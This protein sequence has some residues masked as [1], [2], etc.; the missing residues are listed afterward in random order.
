MNRRL[1]EANELVPANR[2]T[3]VQ[4]TKQA[5][6]SVATTKP[7][8]TAVQPKT[9]TPETENLRNVTPQAETT[10][11]PSVDTSQAE[12]ATFTEVN[13][14]TDTNTTDKAKKTRTT[15]TKS[16]YGIVYDD[17]KTVFSDN[18]ITRAIKDRYLPVTKISINAKGQVVLEPKDKPRPVQP[19]DTNTASTTVTKAKE[20]RVLDDS[21]LKVLESLNIVLPDYMRMTEEVQA[22]NLNS[23]FRKD[24]A[25]YLNS[26]G[27]SIL[28]LIKDNASGRLVGTDNK[29]QSF[30]VDEIDSYLANLKVKSFDDYDTLTNEDL[31]NIKSLLTGTL[32]GFK[33]QL[34]GG[35]KD[36]V[37]TFTLGNVLKSKVTESLI[38]KYKEAN[39]Q[40]TSDES[41]EWDNYIK[42]KN[43]HEN[44][45]FEIEFNTS[46]FIKSGVGKGT[47]VTQKALPLEVVPVIQKDLC[48][49][50]NKK[51]LELKYKQKDNTAEVKYQVTF[52]I[53]NE[54]ST[55]IVSKD[56]V[57][58]TLKVSK[59]KEKQSVGSKIGKGLL[60]GASKLVNTLA[61]ASGAVV[62]ANNASRNSSPVQL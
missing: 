14:N 43:T 20:S 33:T 44:N 2:N 18:E 7:Q 59:V 38:K 13:S 9:Y 42:K 41:A 61:T 58:F 30:Y 22:T 45:S 47:N 35:D 3:T 23:L 60:N 5:N 31:A 15:T 19:V 52:D 28:S 62:Q 8:T 27:I 10:T 56:V 24:I 50:L 53:G 32:K 4:T 12:D 29:G 17:I 48:D 16:G 37:Y 26:R 55:R 54:K 34:K 6:T 57:V 51:K 21:A 25:E 49:Y 1:Y 11:K 40:L 36:I 46:A 39:Y